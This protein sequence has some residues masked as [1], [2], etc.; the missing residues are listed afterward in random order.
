M[1]SNLPVTAICITGPTAT[2]KT[3]LAIAIARDYPVEII[4]VD[5]AMVYRG[6]DIGTAKPDVSVRSR[7]PHHLIDIRDPWERYSAGAFRNDALELIAGIT[8]RGR[9]PLLVGGTLM[10][11]RALQQG[12]ASLPGADAGVRAQLDAEAG[13]LGWPAMHAQLAEVDPDAAAR[14]NQADRQRIQRALEVY[15]LTGR[16]ISELQRSGETDGSIRFRS[17]ALLPDDRQALHER[18]ETRLV[19]MMD[20]GFLDEVRTLRSQPGMTADLPSMR[21]VGYRQLWQHL[22]GEYDLNEAIRRAIVATRRYAKRQVTWL[23]SEDQYEVLSQG[24]QDAM[25]A[26]ASAAES[27]LASGALSGVSR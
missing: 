5:S 6:L 2:G 19:R 8:A 23:R 17:F 7:V 15:R 9:L 20:D 24:S 14:I 25:A 1:N 11:L 18:I 16:P 12:L 13:R 4:S 26:I 21:A 10:Y 3:D 27:A 22:D